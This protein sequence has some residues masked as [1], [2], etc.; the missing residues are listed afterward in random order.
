MRGGYVTYNEDRQIDLPER[1]N[2]EKTIKNLHKIYDTVPLKRGVILSYSDGNDYHSR[3][4]R[5]AYSRV[6]EDAITAIEDILSEEKLKILDQNDIIFQALMA[7]AVGIFLF[8]DLRDDLK[9][10][11]VSVWKHLTTAMQVWLSE[12]LGEDIMSIWFKRSY[13]EVELYVDLPRL[14]DYKDPKIYLDNSVIE[15]GSSI[16]SVEIMHD[17][18]NSKEEI[19]LIQQYQESIDTDSP[20]PNVRRHPTPYGVETFDLHTEIEDSYEESEDQDPKKKKYKLVEKEIKQESKQKTKQRLVEG[21]IRRGEQERLGKE[22]GDVELR[23]LNYCKFCENHSHQ[24]SQCWKI[25]MEEKDRNKL[26]ELD[27]NPPIDDEQ[28]VNSNYYTEL[29]GKNRSG[30]CVINTDQ[31]FIKR[32]ELKLKDNLPRPFNWIVPVVSL[33]DAVLPRFVTYI[34]KK[35]VQVGLT[36][37]DKFLSPLVRTTIKYSEMTVLPPVDMDTRNIS[38]QRTK[39]MRLDP[40]TASV[41]VKSDLIIPALNSISAVIDLNKIFPFKTIPRIP[42]FEVEDF[43]TKIFYDD[44]ESEDDTVL[45]I[46]KE[47]WFNSK[48]LLELPQ[49]VNN[50][51]TR[52]KYRLK[53]MIPHIPRIE[54]IKHDLIQIL[55]YG[56]NRIG[57]IF[58]YARYIPEITEE[59]GVVIDKKL[60]PVIEDAVKNMLKYFCTYNYQ[61]YQTDGFLTTIDVTFNLEMFNTVMSPTYMVRDCEDYVAWERILN[62]VRNMHPINYNSYTEAE[63]RAWMNSAYLA[64][65][66]L[67]CIKFDQR[68]MPLPLPIEDFQM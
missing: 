66:Q 45:D 1:E 58:E 22:D 38:S 12:G 17:E 56:S 40:L 23:K 33:F 16:N 42:V 18:N 41:T 7:V 27:G 68:R 53:P 57:D 25:K 26:I 49:R 28:D 21:S 50:V 35:V 31:M 64:F 62:A 48:S 14:H 60:T 54:D 6:G 43:K 36:A 55:R 3:F 59:Y 5:M 13:Y 11:V 8:D 67:Q 20:R 24:T 44:E 47:E 34:P 52:V 19:L 39:S 2:L 65:L 46:I 15:S 10:K 30:N 4:I 37:V 51:R 29:S 9:N 63:E 61:R 32:G